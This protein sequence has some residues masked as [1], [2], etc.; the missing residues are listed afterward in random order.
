MPGIELLVHDGDAH[1]LKHTTRA[2]RHGDTISVGTLAV[3]VLHT[4]GHS[5]GEC[6]YHLKMPGRPP[7]LF[8]GDTIFIR[9]C[10]RTDLETGSNEQMFES[11]QAIRKLAPETIILPGHHYAP[12][13][14]STLG[15]E[16]LE[17][18]PFRC[19]SVE[20]LASLP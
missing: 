8:T 10:G 9:D 6:S 1:R 4:P 17:S 7:Y 15:R 12:E 18:P 14:A 20:E 16:L 11:I 13:C 3:K 2:I 5:A 19:R